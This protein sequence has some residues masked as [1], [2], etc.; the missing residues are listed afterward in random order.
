M[1]Q[2]RE[3]VKSQPVIL[4]DVYETLFD[5]DVVERRVN[6]L[7]GSK[8][9]YIIWF[10][11][12]MQYCFVDNCTVQFNDFTAI[13]K[14]TM[15]MAAA[16]LNESVSEYDV[17]ETLE[18]LKQVPL[19]NGVS[20]GLSLLNDLGFRVAA[21]TNSPERFV[22]ERMERT[23]LVS[24]FEKLLSAEHVKK[25]KPCIEV[26]EWA[27][28]QMGVAINEVLL[29][30]AHGWDIAGAANAGMQTAY[31][32][33]GRQMLYSLA[34]KPAFTCVDLDDLAHQLQA[35]HEKSIH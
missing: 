26:Y 35:L 23:G 4:L 29:V 18:L 9:G 32:D 14:A 34:P 17:N 31:V 20:Q 25:Y 22:R 30:S 2:T 15:Q 16:R 28:T 8:R 7:L 19:Q 3:P 24:Y 1:E 6:T 12:L 21:L 10:E 11:L 5:M 13:A 33:H 27:A